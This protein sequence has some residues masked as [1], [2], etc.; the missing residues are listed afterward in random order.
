LVAE[1]IAPALARGAVVVSDRFTWSTAAYQGF[2]RGL[3]MES[4][5]ALEVLACAG[6]IPHKVFF[7][8][9]PVD[10]MGQR[11]AGKDADRLESEPAEFFEKVRSGFLAMASRRKNS[12]VVFDAA[13]LPEA[14]A[15]KILQITLEKMKELGLK[16][17]YVT[18]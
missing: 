3:P 10:Q 17:K 12:S 18:S 2:G 14:L 9:L 16:P 15:E 4:I 8:D 6:N 13:T 5:D 11:L 7:L 1:I